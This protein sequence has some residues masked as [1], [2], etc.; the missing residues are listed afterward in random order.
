MFSI[1]KVVIIGIV[2][3]ITFGTNVPKFCQKC[4]KWRTKYKCCEYIC[5]CD[6]CLEIVFGRIAPYQKF[7]KT[8]QGKLLGFLKENDYCTKSELVLGLMHEHQREMQELK[9]TV[10]ELKSKLQHKDQ[11]I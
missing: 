9:V 8:D 2:S 4:S 11:N 7:H 10:K 5:D 1:I 6:K 3:F